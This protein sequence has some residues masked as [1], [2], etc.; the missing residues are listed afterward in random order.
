MPK[1][2]T[3]KFVVVLITG[4]MGSGKTTLG[5]YIRESLNSLDGLLVT[6]MGFADPIK[7]VAE[8]FFN[9]D[10]KKD[11]RGRRLLQV[12]GSEAG[13]A[14]N[15]SI[16]V[17][18]LVAR[19]FDGVFNVTIVDDWRFPNERDCLLSNPFIEVITVGV[20]RDIPTLVNGDHPSETSLSMDV[21]GYDFYINNQGNLDDLFTDGKSVV[22]FIKSEYL[23][24]AEY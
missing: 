22:E 16:W 18:K 15:P 8:A 10:G 11:A 5:K 23:V 17:D 21:H 4:K 20:N 13:R 12:L 9:W 2:R 14:Y 6:Q 3:K 1:Y 7:Y 24:E 19:V